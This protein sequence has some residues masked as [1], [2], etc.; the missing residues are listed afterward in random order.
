MKIPE[1]VKIGAHEYKIYFDVDPSND[2][3]NCF[4]NVSYKKLVIGI[5]PTYAQSQQEETFFHE[6]LHAIEHQLGYE[7]NEQRNQATAHH[8]YLFL[9]ENNL[10]SNQS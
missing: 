1:K 7:E 5:N 9:K 8:L 2:N 6:V 10:L 3:D 4:G